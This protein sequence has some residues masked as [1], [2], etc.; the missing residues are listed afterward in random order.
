MHLNVA[1]VESWYKERYPNLNV[2]D[3]VP[4][5]CIDCFPEIEEGM[6]VQLILKLGQYQV[7]REA[8]GIVKKV[9]KSNEGELYDVRFQKNGKEISEIFCRPEIR[10]VRKVSDQ[11]T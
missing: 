4:G 1:D 10:K 9:Y 7:D 6:E 5:Y 11:N 2:G 8:I 3:P